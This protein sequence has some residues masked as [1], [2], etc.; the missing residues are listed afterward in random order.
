M[1]TIAFVLEELDK[2]TTNT[3]K[4]FQALI[5]TLAKAEDLATLKVEMANGIGSIVSEVRHISKQIGDK[6]KPLETLT[7]TIHQNFLAQHPAYAGKCPC[8]QDTMVLNQNFVLRTRD[9]IAEWEHFYGFSNNSLNATW[10]L[11]TACHDKKDRADIEARNAFR[12]EVE[13]A[14]QVVPVQAR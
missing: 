1:A 7:M 11:C 8:C 4:V 14:F 5:E 9:K 12:A 2:G 10:P 13:A 3:L 6:G